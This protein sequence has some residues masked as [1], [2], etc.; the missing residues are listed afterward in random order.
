M[1]K[2]KRASQYRGDGGDISTAERIAK[3]NAWLS[4][5]ITMISVAS[6]IAIAVLAFI[7]WNSSKAK[8][9]AQSKDYE[10]LF[11]SV[12]PIVTGAL[13]ALFSLIGFN[14]LKN[15]DERQDAM[16]KDLREELREGILPELV[17]KQVDKETAI[18]QDAWSKQLEAQRNEFETL[19][20]ELGE[21]VSAISKLFQDIPGLKGILQDTTDWETVQINNIVWVHDFVQG[22]FENMKKTKTASETAVIFGTIQ[23]IIR[24][25]CSKDSNI[26]G[27]PDDY[28]NLASELARN[29]QLNMA[30]AVLKKGWELF[31]NN[32]DILAGIILFSA[33]LG[34]IEEDIEKSLCNIP[35]EHWNWRAFTFYVD[36]LNLR[37]PTKDNF[38]KTMDKVDAYIRCL[39]T[40][41]RAYMAKYETLERY[42][43]HKE[44]KQ[45]LIDAENDL[46]MTAQCS[47]TLCQIYKMD[48]QFDEAITSATRAIIG[49]AES[50]PSSNTSAAIAER[51]FARDALI[52]KNIMH[53]LRTP[54]E[55]EEDIKAALQDYRLAKELG[56]YGVK[57]VN[58]R[59]S[60]LESLLPKD[61]SGH[62]DTETNNDGANNRKALLILEAIQICGSK[63][64]F[65]ELL[66]S[67]KDLSPITDANS[68]KYDALFLKFAHNDEEKAKRLK[69]IVEEL[70]VG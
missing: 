30:V 58:A 25:V 32:T 40:E 64:A 56:Y 31:P 55:C 27:D 1:S 38:D 16:K 39:P 15:F 44:A 43:K 12:L 63:E 4:A 50:Q 52:H 66:E 26:S 67:L 62:N 41:E 45:A 69:E 8:G 21:Q 37:S 42:G 46:F 33:K 60:I 68:D 19:S 22:Q 59:I 24:V 18:R 13:A 10:N 51:A 14:R 2:G 9:G 6:L 17:R 49:Q 48:G 53:K 20:N 34:I 54:E 61:S 28:H 57:S 36:A 47:L 5:A 11:T 70:F 35:I 7:I 29:S 23:G 65:E 3:R